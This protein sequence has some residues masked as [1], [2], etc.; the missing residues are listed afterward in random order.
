MNS[1]THR[2]NKKATMLTLKMMTERIRIVVL[3]SSSAAGGPPRSLRR[4]KSVASAAVSASR[5]AA[6]LQVSLLLIFTCDL[7]GDWRTRESGRLDARE[8]PDRRL[9]DFAREGSQLSF[10]LH[11]HPLIFFKKLILSFFFSPPPLFVSKKKKKTL[12]LRLSAPSPAP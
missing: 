4:T 5:S 9:I 8:G 12:Q 2:E 1:S 10:D 6:R 11:R 7:R 3:V